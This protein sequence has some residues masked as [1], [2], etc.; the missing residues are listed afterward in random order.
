MSANL[1]AKASTTISVPASRVWDVLDQARDNQT[2]L[3]LNRG[4]IGLRGQPVRLEFKGEW[5]R[6]KIC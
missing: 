1:I 5:G 2:V 4:R 3:L 6:E